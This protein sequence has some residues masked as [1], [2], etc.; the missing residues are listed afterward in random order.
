MSSCDPPFEPCATREAPR[1]HC[2][3]QAPIAT[4]SVAPAALTAIRL[5]GRC[6]E[7]GLGQSPS[8]PVR[9]KR[10]ELGLAG[11]TLQSLGKLGGGAG[12][13]SNGICWL[14][15]D[16]SYKPVKPTAGPVT[17]LIIQDTG[18]QGILIRWAI[19]L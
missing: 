10:L 19:T 17:V 14:E 5:R 13:R 8:I 16:A 4:T 12:R 1:H 3:Y 2:G 6:L 18:E 7:A 11:G 9:I 15:Q